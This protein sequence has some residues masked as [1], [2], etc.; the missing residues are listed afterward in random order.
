MRTWR[1]VITV[2][3]N[4]ARPAEQIARWHVESDSEPGT[5]VGEVLAALEATKQ[6]VL[7]MRVPVAASER[8]EEE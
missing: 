1:V 4:P 8:Q 7:A 3:P 6:Q 5:S 2:E